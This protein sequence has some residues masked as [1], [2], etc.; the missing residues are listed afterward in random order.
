MARDL[1]ETDGVYVIFMRDEISR[2]SRNRDFE[3]ETTF[4]LSVVTYNVYS[5]LLTTMVGYLVGQ[6]GLKRNNF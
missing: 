3:A 5:L 6:R 4:L 1:D 2:P